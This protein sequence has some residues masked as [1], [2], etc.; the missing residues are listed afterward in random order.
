MPVISGNVSLYNESKGSA[1]PPSPMIS[2][3]GTLPNVDSSITFDIK[4]SNS[5]LILI[6]KRQD[7]CGGSVF[8]QL[9]GE[10]GLHLPKPDLSTLNNEIQAVTE[11]IQC[12][13]ILAAHDISEGGVAVTLAE[14]SFKN[15]I[16]VQVEIEGDLATE[17]LLFGESGGFVLE[18]AREHHSALDALFAQYHTPYWIIGQTT[19]QSTLKINSVINLPINV[20]YYAWEHGLRERLL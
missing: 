3:L 4:K 7:E 10:L 16:G 11:A 1:I 13:L 14:M 12:G 2:C 5:L 17:K 15:S 20:A 6:G 8:Y 19:N 9:F 18:V